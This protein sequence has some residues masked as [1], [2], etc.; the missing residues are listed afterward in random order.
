MGM[1]VVLIFLIYLLRPGNLTL[2][3]NNRSFA[4]ST[5]K[6]E[7]EWKEILT[8]EQYY[9]LREKGTEGPF[10]SPLNSEKRPGTYVSADCGEPLFR[11]EQKYDS[12]TGW[13]SFWAPINEDVLVLQEDHDPFI[14]TR[15]EVLS[16]CGGHLGHVFDD[17]PEPTGKRYCMNGDALI[18][19][20]DEASSTIKK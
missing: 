6:T 3:T 11:S 2:V 20:P 12:G 8:P 4:S 10:S 19:I 7:K 9:V 15:V 16:K 17:G 18:F 5:F 13:P 14:G 1:L